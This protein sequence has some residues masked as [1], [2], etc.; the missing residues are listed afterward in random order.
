MTWN[1]SRYPDD[2][3]EIAERVKR[4]AGYCCRHCGHP[5]STVVRGRVLT[6]HHLDGDPGN[7]DDDNL[8]AC[9][10]RCHLHI[11][12]TYRPGQLLLP[13]IDAP[14]WLKERGQ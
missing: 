4:E 11:Q 10:Q 1:R 9:C 8:L 14:A 3:D 2:W 13:G 5:N 12:A 6:V 7:C